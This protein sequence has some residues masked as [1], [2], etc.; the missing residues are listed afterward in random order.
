MRWDWATKVIVHSLIFYSFQTEIEV[1]LSDRS[2]NFVADACACRGRGKKH[3]MYRNPL[4]LSNLDP[5]LQLTQLDLKNP[6]K[7]PLVLYENQNCKQSFAFCS[8]ILIGRNRLLNCV[9]LIT[10]NRILRNISQLGW[11]FLV[12]SFCFRGIYRQIRLCALCFFVG[13]GAKCRLT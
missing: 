7:W 3:A 6:L 9:P 1:L 5:L 10:K 12:A 2:R 4:P 13:F 8:I 11:P